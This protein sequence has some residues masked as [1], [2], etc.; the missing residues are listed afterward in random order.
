M[1]PVRR[2]FGSVDPGWV[3]RNSEAKPFTIHH[4]LMPE[5]S[6]TPAQVEIL[7]RLLRAGFRFLTFERYGAYFAVERDGFVFRTSAKLKGILPERYQTAFQSQPS[8]VSALS[9]HFTEVGYLERNLG[10]QDIAVARKAV[11]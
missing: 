7:E 1:N 8:I 10:D 11:A 6:L 4:F 9:A 3:G 2:F 5:L